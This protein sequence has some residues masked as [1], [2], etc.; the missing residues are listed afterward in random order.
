[1]WQ[2][3]RTGNSP[4]KLATLD[5]KTDRPH[6]TLV[7]SW[8]QSAVSPRFAARRG[9]YGNYVM[10]D[11]GLTVDI[12][13]RC[14][15]CLM[16]NSFVTNA[17]LIERAASCWHLHQLIS[18][19]TQYLDSWLSDL[20]QS[21]LKMK[22]LEVVP[23]CPIGSGATDNSVCE[24]A[25]ETVCNSA[26]KLKGKMPVAV[27]PAPAAKQLLWKPAIIASFRLRPIITAFYTSRRSRHFG[28]RAYARDLR[29]ME[30]DE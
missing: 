15:S 21:E 12:R 23:Q 26:S 18:Q 9:K 22:L 7:L 5:R 6:T 1:V 27:R 16:T 13:A 24:W 14:S 2:A 20:P 28:G 4:T 30:T 17:V 19:T 8:Q 3:A 29:R 10:V 11:G 25:V